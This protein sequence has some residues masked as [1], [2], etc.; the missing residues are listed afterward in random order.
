[1]TISL[2]DEP[3]FLNVRGKNRVIGQKL[4]S[5]KNFF[6]SAMKYD[7]AKEDKAKQESK[8]KKLR[9]IEEAKKMEADKS[10]FQIC[11]INRF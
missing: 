7:A 3:I 11:F 1:M 2:L 5:E 10:K 9:Q 8:Q 4:E 6:V